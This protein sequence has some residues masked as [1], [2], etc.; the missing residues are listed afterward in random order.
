MIDQYCIE[1]FAGISKGRIIRNGESLP[2][3]VAGSF[4]EL[5]DVAYAS[6]SPGYPKFH[7]MDSLSKLGFMTSEYLFQNTNA[8][9]SIDKTKV[10]LV[11][12]N[13]SSSLD[14]DIKFQNM[15]MKGVASP[16]VF[17]YTLPNILIGEICIRNK[18][19]GESV[20]FI[21]ESYNISNQVNY[22]SLLLKNGIV[23]A[24]IGGWVELMKDSYKSFLYLVT[25]CAK[26]K[27][28]DFKEE[29]LSNIFNKI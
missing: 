3:L 11:I 26:G 23:D 28:G 13:K 9:E 15:L 5:M 14:T 4:D 7:K 2:D 19:K 24:C 20:F 10:G 8:L 6:L 12:S 17:V 21:S 22:I 25:K 1:A 18:F 29:N 27:E 16:S